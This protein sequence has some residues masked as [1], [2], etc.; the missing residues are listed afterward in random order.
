MAARGA[1]EGGLR[2]EPGNLVYLKLTGGCE[3][4]QEISMVKDGDVEAAVDLSESAL[5]NLKTYIAWF[6]D[7]RFAYLSQPR[8]KFVNR[9]GEYDHLARRKEWASTPGDGEGS[10]P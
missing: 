6:D 1:F 5:T 2:H 10:T 4:G 9:W 8:A 3:P 7:E